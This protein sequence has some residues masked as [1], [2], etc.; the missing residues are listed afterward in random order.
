MTNE[1][2]A[3][4]IADPTKFIAKI[5]LTDNEGG[6]QTIELYKLTERKTYVIVNGSGGFYISSSYVNKV[7]E[8]IGLF[9]EGKDI[10]IK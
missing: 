4:L 3:A 9:T 6:V 1:E 2:E 7:I 10:N 8:G 5:S